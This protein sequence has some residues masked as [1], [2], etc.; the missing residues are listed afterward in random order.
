MAMRR[1]GSPA[2]L[3]SPSLFASYPTRSLRCP[4]CDQTFAAA[5]RAVTLRCPHCS[6]HVEV[7][8]AVLTRRMMGSIATLGQVHVAKR[9]DFRGRVQCSGLQV[10]GALHGRIVVRGAAAVGAKAAVGGTLT[11]HSIIVAPGARMNVE[12]DIAPPA[13]RAE[14]AP[15]ANV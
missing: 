14:D 1:P 5:L 7:Q 13:R 3:D 11:A 6:E 4:H 2:R 15:A 10:D 12:L 9:G 8:D